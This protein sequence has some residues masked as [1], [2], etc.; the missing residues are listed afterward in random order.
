V[1]QP[2]SHWDPSSGSSNIGLIV[3]VAV[4]AV[5]L[6]VIGF[7]AYRRFKRNQQDYQP[8]AAAPQRYGTA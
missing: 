5:A 1:D 8:F 4:G 2:V 6:A 7:F 3:G